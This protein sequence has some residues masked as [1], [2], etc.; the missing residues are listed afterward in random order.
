MR[1]LVRSSD[2]IPDV[3]L[4][5]SAKLV[6][7]LAFGQQAVLQGQ[8]AYHT[9]SSEGDGFVRFRGVIRS[10][11][12]TANFVYEGYTRSA[13]FPGFIYFPKDWVYVTVLDN[14]GGQRIIYDGKA[15]LGPPTIVG[16]FICTWRE[17][18]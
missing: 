16:K 10:G 8:R 11:Q 15:T 2:E 5:H 3:D 1:L 17:I 13:P 12:V 6:S 4:Y 9:T 7:A 14:S 18:R